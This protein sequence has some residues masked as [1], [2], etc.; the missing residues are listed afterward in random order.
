MRSN[1]QIKNYNGIDLPIAFASKAVIKGEKNKSKKSL[2]RF[3]PQSHIYSTPTSEK[4][5]LGSN[6]FG[7]VVNASELS[8]SFDTIGIL[9][10]PFSVFNI[11]TFGYNGQSY[12]FFI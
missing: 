2:P 7:D 10:I 5:F 3:T 1:T 11:D 6:N 4:F 12:T 8:V 9:Y